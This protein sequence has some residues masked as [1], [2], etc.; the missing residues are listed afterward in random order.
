MLT[1]LPTTLNDL[2][3]LGWDSVDVVLVTGDAYVD[4]P[5]FAIATLSRMLESRGFRVAILSQPDWRSTT[6][7]LTF[8]RP[9]LFFGISAGNMDSMLNHYTAR[10]KPRSNDAFSPGGKAGLRPDRATLVYAHRARGAFPEV[11]IIIGGIEAS[12]RRHA[13]YD[14]WSDSVKRSI[15]LDS[16]ADLLA[17]GMGEY[18]LLE[19]AEALRSGQT[20]KG[21]R[22]LSGIGYSLGASHTPADLPKDGILLPS[23]EEVAEDKK[24]FALATKIIY[25]QNHSDS[26]RSLIQYHDRRAVIVNPPRTPLTGQEFDKIFELPYTRRPHPDYKEP[27]PAYDM[28]KNSIT[29]VRGCFGGCSFCALTLHQG[30]VITSRSKKVR[31]KRD[32]HIG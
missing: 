14:Y 32:L 8:G 10:K 15:L 3:H 30:R 7:W 6:P 12:L 20:L 25:E 27:I 16:K 4:H 24:K 29:I 17:C 28:I 31:A 13:H 9:R 18:T 22:H 5:S 26:G 11:P 1:H 2:H 23:F 19:L 21:L